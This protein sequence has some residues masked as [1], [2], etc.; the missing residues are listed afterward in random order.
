MRAH[1]KWSGSKRFS[2][3]YGR[4]RVDDR[5]SNIYQKLI[6]KF[7]HKNIRNLNGLD[8][9]CGK[10]YFSKE[11]VRNGFKMTCVDPFIDSK[12]LPREIKPCFVKT[13]PLKS[14]NYSLPFKD[15]SFD[16]ITAISVIE[17]IQKEQIPLLL[18]EF[19]RILKQD[20]VILIHVPPFTPAYF[21]NMIKKK[22]SGYIPVFSGSGNLIKRFFDRR[23][24]DKSH[25]TWFKPREIKKFLEQQGFIVVTSL[26]F[27]LKSRMHKK[28]MSGSFY[29]TNINI[30]KKLN[31]MV[32]KNYASLNFYL[33]KLLM[34]PLSLGY[35]VIVRQK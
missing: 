4:E 16:F 2:E 3:Y 23:D 29:R 24:G 27:L 35:T 25:V 31:A 1:K 14:A 19:K 15:D 7:L 10:G 12:I 8:Y 13:T 26:P 11:L 33:F 20:G 32:I 22:T 30:Q 28:E 5:N 18:G 34:T 9:G 21:L 6:T 17:H